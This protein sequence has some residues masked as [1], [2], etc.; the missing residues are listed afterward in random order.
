MK[1]FTLPYRNL[2]TTHFKSRGLPRSNAVLLPA[3]LLPFTANFRR[4]AS[5]LP[6]GSVLILTPP[7]VLSK[8]RS[9]LVKVAAFLRSNGYHVVFNTVDVTHLIPKKTDPPPN[10]ILKQC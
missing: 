7:P 3:S 5:A 4:V 1:H 10:C 8:H 6:T 9:T 2:R